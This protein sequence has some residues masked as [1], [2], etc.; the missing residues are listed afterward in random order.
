MNVLDDAALFICPQDK[1]HQKA[2]YGRQIC[3]G[4]IIYTIELL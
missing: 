3:V 4:R 2:G 1:P